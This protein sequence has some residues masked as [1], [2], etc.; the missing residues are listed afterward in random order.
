MTNIHRDTYSTMIGNH[1]M[2]SY[3]AL[4]QNVRNEKEKEVHKK[5]EKKKKVLQS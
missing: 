3:V 5:V 4:C 1:N 2:I